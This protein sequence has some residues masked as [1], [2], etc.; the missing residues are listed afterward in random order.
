MNDTLCKEW[1]WSNGVSYSKSMRNDKPVIKETNE[2]K[3]TIHNELNAIAQSLNDQLLSC[4]ETLSSRSDVTNRREETYSKM[5]E[6]EMINQIGQNP[7]LMNADYVSD[8]AIQ[9]RFLKPKS[10]TTTEK[11]TA[12]N[13]K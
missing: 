10:T 6:R 7:F 1:K 9:D 5:S 12:N 4:G 8:L 11:S 3:E 13:I 2:I